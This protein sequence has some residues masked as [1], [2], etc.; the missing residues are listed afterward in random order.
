MGKAEKIINPT[1]FVFFKGEE[2]NQAGKI[3]D[4]HF[5]GKRKQQ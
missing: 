1:V 3:N 4:D 5:T 2:G